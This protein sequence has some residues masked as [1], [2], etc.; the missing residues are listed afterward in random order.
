MSKELRYNYRI[1]GY[2]DVQEMCITEFINAAGMCIFTARVFPG[3]SIYEAYEHVTGNEMGMRTLRFFGMRSFT[4]RWA[5]NLREGLRRD[6]FTITD[7]MAGRPPLKG[8]PTAGMTLDEVRLGD[9]FYN[10]LDGT[11]YLD[12]LQFAGG[13]ECVIRDL[14]PDEAPK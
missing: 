2:H 7:R 13:L 12:M 9:N 1:T 5:F 11:P 3:R 8:G 14:Y 4:I 6:D 10:A